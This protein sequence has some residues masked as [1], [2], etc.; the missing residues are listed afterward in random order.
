MLT[1]ISE[2][3]EPIIVSLYLECLLALRQFDEI[4]DFISSLDEETGSDKEI[5]K[6]I[7]K[8]S[9]VKESKIQSQ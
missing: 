6:I 1:F 9:I 7:K 2:K 4:D 8:I 3:A 5:K